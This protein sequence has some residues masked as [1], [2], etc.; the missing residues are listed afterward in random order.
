MTLQSVSFLL[1]L[2]VV[3]TAY[4]LLPQRLRNGFLLLASYAFYLLTMPQYAPLLLGMT[5]ISY[6]VARRLDAPNKPKGRK[7]WMLASIGLYI[8]VLCVFKYF[9]LFTKVFAGWGWMNTDSALTLLMPIGISFYT[10]QIIGYTV[11]VYHN[12]V[13]AERNIIVYALFVSFF[14]QILAGPIGRA[15]ELLPQYHAAPAFHYE[16]VV[17][18][19]Q[20]FLLGAFKKVVVADSLGIFVNGIY[21]NLEHYQGFS[22]LFVILAYAGQFYFDFAGYT[23][24]AIGV[25]KILGFQLRENF[26]APYLSTNFSEFW[27]RWHIS[28]STWFRDYIYIPLGGNRKGFARKLLHLLIVFAVSGLW[29]G[30]T[31]NFLIWGLLQGILRIAEELW[32]RK[33]REA[34]EN[35]FFVRNLKRLG[36]F[37]TWAIT[38]VFFRAETLA[39]AGYV[40]RNLVTHLS[41]ATTVTQILYLA[42]NGI[43]NTGTY[44]LFFFG[45]LGMALLLCAYFDWRTYPQTV[46]NNALAAV[47]RRKRWA[48]Y[49]VMGI[50]VMLFYFIALTGATGAL[51][52]IYK[53]F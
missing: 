19:M 12:K 34:K 50:A 30:S 53:G 49:W 52:I 5:A 43:A 6:F 31:V 9:G 38:L 44:Y 18:G 42:S 45:T 51:G 35:G 17:G 20:R 8:L 7:A 37:G 22:L 14:P 16:N 13:A 11:D 21:G 2:A 4:Y 39:D 48:L 10:F 28:L 41:P 23:D 46:S 27:Q 40:L 1:F 32:K 26:K 3:A 25:A 24:M 33:K 47:G 15:G 29:H 36:V